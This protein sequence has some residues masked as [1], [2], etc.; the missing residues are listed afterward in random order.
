MEWYNVEVL[1]SEAGKLKRFLDS[2][3][4][5][6]EASEAGNMIHFEVFCDLAKAARINA[7]LDSL[8]W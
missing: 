5:K 6:F 7:F 1:R 3:G 2:Y 4:V 8:E